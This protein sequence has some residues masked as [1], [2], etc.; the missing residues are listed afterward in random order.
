MLFRS[1]LLDHELKE[2]LNRED[3]N[4]FE[5]HVRANKNYHS[6]IDGAKELLLTGATSVEEVMRVMDDVSL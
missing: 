3:M 4:A 1:Y 6:L 2:D 5:Q